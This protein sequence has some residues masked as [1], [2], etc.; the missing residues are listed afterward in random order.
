[1]E[2]VGGRECVLAGIAVAGLHGAGFAVPMK[3]RNEFDYRK[4]W[5]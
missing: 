4:G 2:A 3:R 1:M 5:A